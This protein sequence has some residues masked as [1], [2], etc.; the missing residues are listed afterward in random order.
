[1]LTLQNV[2]ELDSVGQ[3]NKDQSKNLFGEKY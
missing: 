1:M 2:S 3:L